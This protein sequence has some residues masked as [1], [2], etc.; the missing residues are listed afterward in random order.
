VLNVSTLGLEGGA[1]DNAP[2][3]PKNPPL[4]VVG[5]L[6]VGVIAALSDC[7]E[8]LREGPREGAGVG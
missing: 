5:V 1:S 3:L 8:G 7:V 2:N 4:G 6:G